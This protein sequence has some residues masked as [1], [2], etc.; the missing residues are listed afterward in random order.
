MR[1]GKSRIKPV[2][3]DELTPEQTELLGPYRNERGLLNIYRTMATNVPAA[4]GFLGWGRYVLRQS[5]LDARLR[6]I[7]ILRVGWL[8]R[9]G[10]EWTQHS[11]LAVSIGMTDVELGAIKVG[12][13]DQYW[14]ETE[15]CLLKAVDELHADHFVSDSTWADLSQRLSQSD[16]MDL[17]FVVGHYTQVCMILNSFGVQVEGDQKVDPDLVD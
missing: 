6:E 10:Y 2:D 9:S 7:A 12:A 15:R 14:G 4:K 1:L 11:R 16:L 17:V 3:D 8:C 13:D 5:G